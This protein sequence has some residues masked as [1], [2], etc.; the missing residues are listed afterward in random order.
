[1]LFHLLVTLC[2]ALSAVHDMTPDVILY[3]FCVH[4]VDLPKYDQPTTNGMAID[5]IRRA[6]QHMYP[7]APALATTLSVSPG[8]RSM[9]RTHSVAP[10]AAC[11]RLPVAGVMGAAAPSVSSQASAPRSMAAATGRPVE[12]AASSVAVRK[13]RMAAPMCVHV[14]AGVARSVVIHAPRVSGGCGAVASVPSSVGACKGRVSPLKAAVAVAVAATPAAAANSGAVRREPLGVINE[15]SMK[16][17]TT[18]AMMKG[19]LRATHIT[20]VR[21]RVWG[22]GG[23]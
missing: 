14:V 19:P 12:A 4:Q 7:L 5:T 8:V 17:P 21:T 13:G 3:V 6:L 20:K 9:A 16:A 1:M 2:A 23:E 18:Q 11:P 10:T 22:G 15:N